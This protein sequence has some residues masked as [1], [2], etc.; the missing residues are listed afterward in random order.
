MLWM[1]G[2]TLLALV[3]MM[4]LSRGAVG[5]GEVE[6]ET[7]EA[8]RAELR[9]ARA[10]RQEAEAALKGAQA[11][12]AELD[13]ASDDDDEA[14]QALTEEN[15]RLQQRVRELVAELAVLTD[16]PMVVETAAALPVARAAGGVLAPRVLQDV[17][18]VD[19][20]PG[21]AYAVIDVGEEHGVRPGMQ[22]VV[23]REGRTVARVTAEDVREVLTGV[24]V[25]LADGGNFPLPG[26][27]AIWTT[28]E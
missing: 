7:V 19:A 11:R 25:S 27:R 22:F 21:I 12:L 20:N 9:Q 8:I 24:S 18:V 10:E 17:R 1:G 4:A 26:D 15:A 23:M 2:V 16:R 6:A 3:G 13:D 5:A 28:N 14:W